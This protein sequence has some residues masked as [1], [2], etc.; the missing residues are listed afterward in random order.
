MTLVLDTHPEPAER[1]PIL[2]Q[3]DPRLRVLAVGVFAVAV[4]TLESFVALG[5]ALA[6]AVAALI[7]VRLPMGRTIKQVV[8]VD[9]F[10]IF[11]VISLP[12]TTPGET[13]FTLLGFPATWEGIGDGFRIALKANA[14]VLAMLTLVGT[15]GPVELGHTLARLRVPAMLVHLLLFTIRYIEVLHAEYQRLRIAMRTR[16]FRA[17]TDM[18]TLR[19]FG[20]LIGMLLIRALDRSERIMQAMRCRG[21]NGTFP[22][23]YSPTFSARRDMSFVLAFALVLSTLIALEVAGAGVV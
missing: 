13:A 14:I 4:V 5:F 6:L 10:M 23:L 18:H 20:Y 8:T 15:I 11:V 7:H 16:G 19:T 12:F 21:F 17:R 2:R 22:L 1:A 3:V 9:T